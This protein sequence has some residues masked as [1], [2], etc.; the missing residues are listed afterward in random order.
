[1]AAII[2]AAP[3]PMIPI[4]IPFSPFLLYDKKKRQNSHKIAECIRI[5][6]FR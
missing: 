2:P 5:K 4:S 3:P 1:M 6:Q